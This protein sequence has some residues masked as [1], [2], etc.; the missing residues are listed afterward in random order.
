MSRVDARRARPS[1]LGRWVLSAL[2]L[3]S[4]SPLWSSVAGAVN[5]VAEALLP[6]MA[7]LVIDGERVT[8]RRGQ[9][10]GLVRLVDVENQQAVL[11]ID[12][13]T[14]RVGMSE[15]VGS[16]YREP[17]RR[18]LRILRNDQLQYITTAEING[19]RV[20]VLVDTGANLV[21]ISGVQAQA[22]GI[23]PEEG[24]LSQVQTASERRPAR[25]VMLDS[26]SVGG[27]RVDAVPAVIIDGPQPETILLGMSYLR[28]VS[29]VEEAGVLSL[30][31]RW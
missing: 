17:E 7:V 24:V 5:V 14:H 23:G 13:E 27:I 20:R 16:R 31:A 8:L 30:T 28:H 26:V 11:V 4:L 18:E 19:R 1:R 2:F 22:L 12:G 6:G 21:A 10:H 25:Q 9:S 29:L 3:S 15:H